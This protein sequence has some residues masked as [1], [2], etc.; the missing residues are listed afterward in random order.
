MDRIITL[1]TD[2]GLKDPY[3]GAMKGAILSVNPRAVIVD[4]SHMVEPGNILEG[5]FVLSG[6]CGLFPDGTI[7]V[8]VVDP[9]VGGERKP[10]AVEAGRHLFVGPDNGLL[11]LV[12]REA[13]FRGAVELKDGSYFR[14]EVSSTFHGRDIFG[15]VAAHLSLGARTGSLGPALERISALEMPRPVVAEDGIRGEVI[16]VDSFGNLITNI[17]SEDLSAFIAPSVEVVIKDTGLKGLK[18]TY[19][20]AEKGRPL[21]LMGSSGLLEIAVNSGSAAKGLSAGIGEAVLVRALR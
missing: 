16:Y 14:R 7:H 4:I 18:R 5:A 20:T 12:A 9:G 6:A 8:A 13:G 19:S 10:V 2:F 1:T 17:R 3:V 21:A 11:S 15:P